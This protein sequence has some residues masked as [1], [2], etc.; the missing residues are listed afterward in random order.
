MARRRVYTPRVPD[1][2]VPPVRRPNPFAVH[3][4]EQAQ[5]SLPRPTMSEA[6]EKRIQTLQSRQNLGVSR[7]SAPTPPRRQLSN[8][9]I[10]KWRRNAAWSTASSIASDDSFIPPFLRTLPPKD[11]SPEKSSL[12][13]PTKA[14]TP[15]RVVDF[16][17]SVLS[18][19]EQE[20]ARQKRREQ[21]ADL[22]QFAQSMLWPRMSVFDDDSNR[23]EPPLLYGYG[24]SQQGSSGANDKENQ[25]GSDVSD[26]SMSDA[27]PLE[28]QAPKP[29]LSQ[30][31]WTNRH[32]LLLK[33]MIRARRQRPFAERYE[34]RSDQ[35]LGKTVRGRDAV[36][37][38]E[39][40]HLDCVDAFGAEVGGWDEGDLVKRLFGLLAAEAK[41]SGKA[42]QGRQRAVMFQ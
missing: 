20:L 25:Q 2:F 7:K 8:D 12:R 19:P 24:Q 27:P 21:E 33:K 37:E 16:T 34:R 10:R 31:V 30:T 13:P 40:W 29:A 17:S 42:P 4:R 9:D 18:P 32:W 5:Q 3:S 15:G 41:R 39:R 38:L 11:A 35:Y 14:H 23:R 26:V 1:D 28:Q 6:L 22:E 36:L